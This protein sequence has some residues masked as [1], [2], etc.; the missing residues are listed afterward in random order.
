MQDFTGERD[1]VSAVQSDFPGTCTMED[2]YR[3]SL[4]LKRGFSAATDPVL[5][6]QV[7]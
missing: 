4:I 1:S 6:L 2:E 7:G 5:V 3:I